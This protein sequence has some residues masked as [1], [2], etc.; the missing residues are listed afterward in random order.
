MKLE[1]PDPKNE[2]NYLNY[3]AKPIPK[4]ISEED[5]SDY[6]VIKLEGEKTKKRQDKN[7][8]GRGN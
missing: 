3:T 2:K 6:V 4:E 8:E 7:K 5:L 1:W